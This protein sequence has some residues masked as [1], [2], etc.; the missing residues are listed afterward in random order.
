MPHFTF[1]TFRCCRSGALVCI[2]FLLLFCGSLQM[3]AQTCNLL[4]NPD[5]ENPQNGGWH[6][7]QN[8]LFPCWYTT[9]ADSDIEVW[10][11]GFNG[12]PA[13]SGNQFIELNANLV[14]TMYQNFVAN[15]GTHL[16]IGFAH[17]GRAGVDT[18]SVSIGPVGGPYTTIG[19]FGDGNTAWSYRYL[20]FT[21]PTGGGNYYSLRFNSVY[22]TGGDQ[23]IGNFLDDIVVSLPGPDLVSA[24]STA[25]HCFGSA[26]GTATATA[27]G[28]L[29]PYSYFWS[30]SGG[31]SA[32]ANNLTGG[33]YTITTRDANGC[34]ASTTILVS[35]P[36]AI[37]QSMHTTPASCSGPPNGTVTVTPSGGMAPYT[38]SW[39]PGAQTTASING[40][41]AGIY[42]CYVTDSKGCSSSDTVSITQPPPISL[43]YTSNTVNCSG[44]H[45]G[46]ITV[47]PGG[48]TGAYTYSWSPGNQT[49]ATISNQDTGS[50]TVTVTDAQG[51]SSNTSITLSHPPPISQSL[52]STPV[53]CTGP[54]NG[55]ATTLP[56]SGTSPYTY[57][58][59]P[60]GA[61]SATVSNLALGLYTCLVTD[62]KGCTGKD[63]I[64]VSPDPAITD[65][66]HAQAATCQGPNT[67]TS[68]VYPF[69][70]T[71]P[72]TYHWM[73]GG[74][75]GQ[76]ATNLSPGT[77]TITITD[78]LG[79]TS[80][81]TARVTQPVKMVIALSSIVNTTCGLN[82]GQ[83][84]ATTTGGTAPY[85]YS[86]SPGGLSGISVSGLAAG[87]YTVNATDVNNCP[88]A[89]TFTIQ[90]SNPPVPAS[91]T[92]SDTSGC[93]LLCVHFT[94]TTS[95]TVNSSNWN[96][97]DGTNG[98]GTT[99]THCYSKSGSYT[100][101]LTT[102]DANSCH[103][104]ALHPNMIHVYPTPVAAFSYTPNPANTNG[105]THFT[106]GS[107]GATT[108]FWNFSGGGNSTLPNPTYTYPNNGIF[109]TT[110]TVTNSFGCTDSI[111][112]EIPVETNE[113]FLIPNVF[114]P[115][116]DGKNDFFLITAD[117]YPGFHI[118]IYDRWGVRVFVS[119]DRTDPWN[120]KLF[121]TGNTVSDGT[122]Y[123]L[124]GLT[125]RS[126]NPKSY[127]GFVTLLRNH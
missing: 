84:V 106:D 94:N 78:A 55:T 89:T 1:P 83:A 88:A 28:G 103:S 71:T 107:T 121:N 31:N 126:G 9:A 16:S 54:P 5:F 8:S 100:A 87:T 74:Q 2:A 20:S 46:T 6:M 127:T 15:P 124:L 48:G 58:W 26:D 91:F 37:A 120:G 99:V 41:A 119:D 125:D 60:G 65:S 123:Y 117:A 44:P 102:T 47:T 105:P 49:S 113:A 32:T 90:L 61:T 115:D 98:S 11:T 66:T 67:G 85:T 112:K 57:S 111:S 36:P 63:T 110:L 7:T 116:G 86:W 33:T 114:T 109:L 25:A 18:M 22:A 14:A 13:Y 30:P 59:S 64:R 95:G 93:P 81:D 82:N 56:G 38:Y 52:N 68:T 40:L 29:A 17:R 51:C 4:C 62:S 96:F 10:W 45:N 34:S 76:A 79:C 42:T 35:Q 104:S 97:G 72:Y 24:T 21:I 118:V 50:Y 12:V 92:G 101:T 3:Q 39:D 69:G 80:K 53:G 70:G 43:A 23:S 19:T 27:T 77:Y 75:T 73:P 122:Y 108:W